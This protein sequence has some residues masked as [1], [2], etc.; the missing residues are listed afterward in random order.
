MYPCSTIDSHHIV[1]EQG[2]ATRY[3][4]AGVFS[5]RAAGCAMEP[6]FPEGLILIVDASLNADVG[7]FVLTRT[8][9]SDQTL[10]RQL[11]WQDG[12]YFLHALNPFFADLPL[13]H[14]E[15][16]GV[17]RETVRRLR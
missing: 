9:D 12:E 6:L 11:I 4:T 13:A 5:L 1:S 16:I 14:H 8:E 17:L 10:F 2:S 15:I 3:M 7:D